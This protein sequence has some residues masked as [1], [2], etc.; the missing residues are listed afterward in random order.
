M[1]RDA[2]GRHEPHFGR[3][4]PHHGDTEVGPLGAAWGLIGRRGRPD[5]AILCR[6]ASAVPRTLAT[7]L[8]VALVLWA[9]LATSDEVVS[10]LAVVV[11]LLL[12]LQVHDRKRIADLENGREDE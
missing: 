8:A 10:V 9:A 12:V 4:D 7:V 6:R 11:G 5:V 2:A 1:S 3:H